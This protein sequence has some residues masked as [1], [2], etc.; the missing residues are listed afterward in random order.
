MK[1]KLHLMAGSAVGISEATILLCTK[2]PIEATCF[3]IPAIVGS[4]LPDSDLPNTKIGIKLP[5]ISN[6]INR[7]FGHRGFVHTPLCGAL[8]A[9]GLYA[10]INKLIGPE[11]AWIAAAGLIC[12]Y[13]VHLFQD[14]F[15]KGGIPLFYP[16]SRSRISFTKLR[17]NSK[18]HTFI[19]IGILIGWFYFIIPIS[20]I[21]LRV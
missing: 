3:V 9:V 4:L 14:M 2:G 17:S 15:T 11:Y 19:T 8:I 16:I 12:G 6:L 10:A 7:L 20:K 18:I 1:G 5:Y 21:I 13:S